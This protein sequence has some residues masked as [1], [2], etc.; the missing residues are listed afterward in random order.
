M[1]EGT[2]KVNI[3]STERE[4]SFIVLNQPVGSRSGPDLSI[5][6][7]GRIRL[8][9]EWLS[10]ITFNCGSFEQEEDN[11]HCQSVM[12]TM[13]MEMVDGHI[14]TFYQILSR[15]STQDSPGTENQQN[16]R[17][18]STVAK[19]ESKRNEAEKDL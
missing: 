3:G 14:S 7:K 12:M 8:K 5:D 1:G 17:Q 9:V 15:E 4:R 11:Q 6:A 13:M 19:T 10:C 18:R 16:S 2:C